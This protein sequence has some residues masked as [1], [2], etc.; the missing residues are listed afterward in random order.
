MHWAKML[1]Q[2]W[3]VIYFSSLE[4]HLRF[5]FFRLQEHR[6]F[7]TTMNGFK[8]R[9][10]NETNIVGGTYLSPLVEFTLPDTVDWRTKGYVTAIKDQ[11]QCGSCWSFSAVSLLSSAHPACFIQFQHSY[12][13]ISDWLTGGTNLP[14]NRKA[15]LAERTEPGGLLEEVGQRRL[16]WRTH[17]P[18]LPVHRRQ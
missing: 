8:M 5:E 7:V 6:E 14:Q 3:C 10:S 17:G 18:S 16:Q 4:L 2:I 9:T 1:T 15:H 12:G 13:L 11:G